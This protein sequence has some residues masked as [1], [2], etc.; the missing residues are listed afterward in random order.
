MRDLLANNATRTLGFYCPSGRITRDALLW[1]GRC[2][3]VPIR[4]MATTGPTARVAERQRLQDPVAVVQADAR[5]Y[6]IRM[7]RSGG[8]NG[9]DAVA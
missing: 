5:V 1:L 6:V 3:G 4:E 2:R 8:S 7:A 9:G